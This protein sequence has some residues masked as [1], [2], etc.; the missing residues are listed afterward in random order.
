MLMCAIQGN[1][2]PSVSWI[3]PDGT[4]A[5]SKGITLTNEG[6][7]PLNNAQADSA[8][9]YTCVASNTLGSGNDSTVVTI[10]GTVTGRVCGLFLSRGLW[11]RVL[12]DFN[13][14]PPLL[15]SQGSK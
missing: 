1:P 15:S 7:L 10:R 8:G 2:R 5:R 4:A 6:G 3:F 9:A 11:R 12:W 14:L 13:L